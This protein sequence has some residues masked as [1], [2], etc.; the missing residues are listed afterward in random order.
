MAIT[1]TENAAK[2]IRSALAKRG[3]V[4]CVL[5]SRRSAALVSRTPSITPMKSVPMTKCSKPATSRFVVDRKRPG[6]RGRSVLRLRARRLERIV[7][8]EN[9]KARRCAAV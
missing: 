8:V 5:A 9:P 6:V 7:Q 2:H 3:G 1:V 4:G